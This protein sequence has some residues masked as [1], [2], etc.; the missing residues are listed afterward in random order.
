M[1]TAADIARDFV[2]VSALAGIR[3]QNS[4][5]EIDELPAPHRWPRRLPCGRY[6][7]YVFMHN[8]RCLKVGKAG[9]KS[10]ARYCS[11]HYGMKAPST[12]AKSLLAN[13]SR[14]GIDRLDE[15]SAGKWICENTSRINFL[16]PCS[17]GIFLLSL[18]EAF[19]QCRLNPEFEGFRTQRRVEPVEALSSDD[20]AAS[21]V[22]FY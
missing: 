9:P 1:I 18:L 13:Y 3:I 19:V 6:A 10:T 8:G 12:L 17:Y 4:D 7:V 22:D 14:L 21:N 2:E 20:T 16:V 11:Q 15:A 5:I